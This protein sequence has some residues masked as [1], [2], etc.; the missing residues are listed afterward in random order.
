MRADRY[1]R[2]VAS[3]A[4]L[5]HD[6]ANWRSADFRNSFFGSETDIRFPAVKLLDFAAHEGM[7][8]ASNNPFAQVVL[9]HLR[10]MPDIQEIH[11]AE[12]LRAILK[13][14]ET[15]TRLDEVRRLWAPQT[16]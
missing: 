12:T 4:V 13:V 15:A 16:P 10:L 11:E 1:N 8:E 2:P 7:L 6:D 5:A 9:A 14:L 3:L